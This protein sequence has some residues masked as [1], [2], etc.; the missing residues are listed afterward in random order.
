L[1]VVDY[2]PNRNFERLLSSAAKLFP[3]GRKAMGILR[4]PQPNLGTNK[5]ADNG[6]PFIGDGN[7]G[8]VS[9][10]QNYV[11]HF[12]WIDLFPTTLD[13]LR[14]FAKNLGIFAVNFNG[15]TSN[16]PPV[17]MKGLEPFQ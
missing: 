12:R 14:S 10:L 2:Y 6:V 3:L 7:S 4:L 8:S 11:F 13:E 9:H 16:Q 5:I 1:P 17:F 15:V